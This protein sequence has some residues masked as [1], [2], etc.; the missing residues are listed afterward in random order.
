MTDKELLTLTEEVLRV[1]TKNQEIMRDDSISPT[2][3][4]KLV[5]NNFLG[6]LIM[7][8][9]LSYAELM[10]HTRAMETNQ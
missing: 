7:F 6:I 9:H 8:P 3:S 10:A 4:G 2:L 1:W 5:R